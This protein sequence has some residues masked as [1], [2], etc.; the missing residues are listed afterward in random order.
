MGAKTKA[1]LF[2][3]FT[4][5]TGIGIGLWAGGRIFE[6]RVQNIRVMGSRNGLQDFLNEELNLNIEQA[7]A[8]KQVLEEHFPRMKQIHLDFFEE[9]KKEA[10]SLDSAIMP[11]L[12][13]AQQ[14]KWQDHQKRMQ[15]RDRKRKR[16]G[17]PPE[18]QKP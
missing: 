2:I 7:E 4:L 1:I 13:P 11:L 9:R 5:I 18:R 3:F 17:P 16:G 15:R 6:N 8:V 10:A 12:T 14:A